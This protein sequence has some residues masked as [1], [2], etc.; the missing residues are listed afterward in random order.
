LVTD[1]LSKYA[2]TITGEA[3]TIGSYKVKKATAKINGE[4]IIAWYTPDLPIQDGS[5]DY[6]GLP[7]LIIELIG[8]KKT[9]Q[10]VKVATN[11]SGLIITKPS[12]GEKVN[13]ERYYKIL[14]EKINELK[15]G[16]GNSLGN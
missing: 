1:Q 6:Y 10:A 12:K 9:Y 15:Q 11:K 4:N 7:G 16:I 2:W 8:E 14:N 3:K 5:K 13:K